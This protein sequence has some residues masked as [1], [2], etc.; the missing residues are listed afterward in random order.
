VV[1]HTN[2]VPK[3]TTPPLTRFL[4]TQADNTASVRFSSGHAGQSVLV[5][6]AGGYI[7]S[8]FV[9]A[10]AAAGPSR[11][12]LLDSAEHN[13]FQIH[14]SLESAFPDVPCDPVL[15]SVDDVSL[16]DDI[17]SRFQPEV[18]YHAAAFKHVPLMERNPLAAVRNNALG[19]YTMAQAARRHGTPKLILISTDKA[20]N[21]HSVLGV[22]KRIAELAV[23]GLSSPACRMN[24]IRLANVIGSTGSVVPIFLRQIAERRPVTVIHPDATRWF[25]SL[26]QTV[27]AILAC[28][29][30]E[31]DGRILVPELGE[32][33][34]I[35]DLATFLIGSA[36]VP[37][38]FTG[39]RPGDKLT[40]ELVSKSETKE[41][42][43]EGPLEVYRT[44]RIQP[45]A[46]EGIMQ[47]LSDCIAARDV[48]LLIRT[49]CSVIPEYV[50]G[51]LLRRG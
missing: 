26:N 19:T 29:T 9:Q 28:G 47:R 21:P 51:D 10:I 30:A 32:P 44:C 8:A 37:I 17:L 1:S 46:L 24:A 13:L 39:C 2:R 34:R 48:A 3:A 12:I 40:E 16:M 42:T 11:I 7:A 15:G 18:I 43:I 33:V 35:A 6:G 31:I 4:P 45:A 49:L 25:L 38:L 5:T 22:S 50:P 27:D 14:R 20:V 36:E 41:G 23:V